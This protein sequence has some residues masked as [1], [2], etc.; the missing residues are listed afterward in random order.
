M[1]RGLQQWHI[2]FRLRRHAPGFHLPERA[3]QAEDA[4]HIRARQQRIQPLLKLAEGDASAQFARNGGTELHHCGERRR[5]PGRGRIHPAIRAHLIN[6]TAQH[7]HFAVQPVERADADIALSRQPAARR[8]AVV[9][10][11]EQGINRADLRDRISRRGTAG[12]QY[13][14]DHG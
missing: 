11:G 3:R 5:D 13:D 6:T 14:R 4:N 10:P 7:D 2:R 9:S 8:L 1:A 12:E